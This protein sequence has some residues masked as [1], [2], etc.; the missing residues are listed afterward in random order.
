MLNGKDDFRFVL[1]TAQ[2]PLFE[3][4]GTP[5]KDKRFVLY[6]GGHDTVTR[7]D[8]IKEALDWLDK[9]LGEVKAR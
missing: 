6:E 9:Y 1:E 2:R 7:V 5:P 3:A 8:A 4:M